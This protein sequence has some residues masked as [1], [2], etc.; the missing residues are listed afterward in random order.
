VIRYHRAVVT[1]EELSD[2]LRAA[3]AERDGAVRALLRSGRSQE[4]VAALLGIVAG[5]LPTSAAAS[6]S[7]RRAGRAAPG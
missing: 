6:K 1:A 4:Q 5:D 2:Q 3:E 7:K